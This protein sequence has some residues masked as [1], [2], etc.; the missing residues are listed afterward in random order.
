MSFDISPEFLSRWVVDVYALGTLLLAAWAVACWPVRQPSR[1]LAIARATAFGLILFMVLGTLPGWPR[2]SW[3][4]TT[5]EAGIPRTDIRSADFPAPGPQPWADAAVIEPVQLAAHEQTI[6]ARA[7]EPTRAPAPVRAA[8]TLAWP[9]VS[10]LTSWAIR[11]YLTGAIAAVL[12]LAIGAIQAGR[13]L[14]ASRPA[15]EGLR[16]WLCGAVGRLRISARIGQPMAVGLFRPAIVL[17]EAWATNESEDETLAAAIRHEEAHVRNGDLLQLAI[18]RLLLPVFYLH[19]LYWRLRRRVRLDQELLADAAAIGGDR[20]A[21]AGTLLAWARS[22]FGSASGERFAGALALA[23]RPSELYQ[24]IAALLDPKW[25]VDVRCPG[26]WRAGAWSVVLL[27]ALGLSFGTLRPAAAGAKAEATAPTTAEPAP[28]PTTDNAIV[29]RG[30]VVDPDGRPFAGASLYLSVFHLSGH[31]RNATQPVRGRSGPDGQF[32]FAVPIEEFGEPEMEVHRGVRVLAMADGYATGASDSL[33]PDADHELTVRL[34]RD[35]VPVAGTLVDLEGR[36]VAGATVHVQSIDG[37]PGGDLSQWLTEAVGRRSGNYE[38]RSRH[39]RRV[40]YPG[41][42]GMPAIADATTASDGRFTL[43]GVGRERIAS[44]RVEG[45]S[46][47]TMEALVMTHRGEPLRIGMFASRKNDRIVVYHPA[48]FELT[49]PPSR[50]VEGIVRD[51]DTGT[52]IAGATIHSF[53]LADDELGNNQIVRTKT[54]R[55]GRFRLTGLPLGKGNE[56]YI[57]SPEDQPYLPSVRKLDELTAAAPLRVELVLKRG[58]WLTGRVTERGT[59]H[60]A[61]AY[62]RYAAAKDNPHL[63]EAPGFADII[64]NGDYS[65]A[66]ETEGSNY[67]IAV[68]PGRGLVA[69]WANGATYPAVDPEEAGFPRLDNYLPALYWGN[70]FAEINARTEG[71]APKADLVLDPGRTVEVRVVDPEGKPLAGARVNGRWPVRGWDGKLQSDRF[72]VHGLVPPKPLGLGGLMRAGNIDQM[73]EMIRFHRPRLVVV[74]HE[75][76]RLAGW[77]EVSADAKG[78][79]AIRLRPWGVVSGRLVDT[80][81][82][83]RARITFRP[84][85]IDVLKV[86]VGL[87]DHWPARCTTDASGHFRVE[88]LAPGLRYRLSLETAVGAVNSLRGPEVAPL[89]AGEHRELGNVVATLPGESG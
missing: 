53:R 12:W 21:Y 85:V 35:D 36:P 86:G 34:A 23:E 1:R 58:V 15:P 47:R 3:R 7:N 14:R 9:D 52:P 43:R 40:R 76:R 28:D 25:N 56:I 8:S 50:P 57:F 19:P 73:A 54:E 16:R 49:A 77:A 37:T 51:R 44:I 31:D 18:L 88:G 78:P 39:L 55:D 62:I 5:A 75:A 38:L 87:G 70:A 2:A 68:L 26:A 60:A 61:Q 67:R 22:G 46:I 65:T 30:R 71:P 69:A 59:G 63:A 24:R 11:A 64:G 79:V 66:R 72:T 13:L 10:I 84:E 29:F 74:Q 89:A 48:R 17:P 45:P 80:G 6:A 82:E 33:E 32:R 20:T 41:Y 4:E 42:D 83:P 81:G 27:A